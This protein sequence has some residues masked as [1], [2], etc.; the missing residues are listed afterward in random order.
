[1]GKRGHAS[2]GERLVAAS[3]DL[4]G[5]EGSFLTRQED[6]EWRESR[7]RRQS[8]VADTR[9][10]P[11]YVLAAVFSSLRRASGRGTVLVRCASAGSKRTES[12]ESESSLR[13][14]EEH[15]RCYHCRF[16]LFFPRCRSIGPEPLPSVSSSKEGTNLFM[17]YLCKK[18]TGVA[19]SRRRNGRS[20]FPESLPTDTT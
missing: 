9:R 16:F 1:M 4:D 2:E 6:D 17:K 5:R 20:L 11:S 10:T 3:S 14:G 15:C 12:V 8:K 18:R 13:D 19:W 7:D